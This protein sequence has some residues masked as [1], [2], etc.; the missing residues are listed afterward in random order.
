MAQP[1]DDFRALI[2]QLPPPDEA[3][4]GRV[5]SVFASGGRRPGELGRIE[6]IAT[7]LARWSGRAPNVRRPL[8]A[9]FAGTHAIGTRGI[10]AEP[11]EAIARFVETCAAGGAPVN[12]ACLAGD[13]GLKVFDLALDLPTGD[14]TREAALDERGCAATMVFGMEAVASGT[15]LLCVAG[16]GIGEETIAGAMLAAL[17]G[18]S[19]RDWVE[20]D[21]RIDS[22]IAEQRVSVVDQA[23]TLHRDHASD[24][25]EVL[26]RLGG[27]EFAAI[28]GAVLAA[29]MER[30]PVILDGPAALAAATVLYELEPEAVRHCLL[31]QAPAGS[32]FGKAV[33]ALGLTPLLDLRILNGQGVAAVM[34]AGAVKAAAQVS[35]T[36]AEASRTVTEA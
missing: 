35:A 7:W 1:F 30:V 26:R 3:A 31:A 11:Q 22:A 29:R 19:G 32:G 27:R 12:G 15:D 16:L 9:L 17:L 25:L 28:V 5:R 4:A 10:A 21:T 23:L 18:G 8:V 36:L 33:A 6:E 13:I 14:I 2:K 24:A 34:A 20:T